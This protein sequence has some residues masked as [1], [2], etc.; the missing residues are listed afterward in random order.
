MTKK[1]KE[2]PKN[3]SICAQITSKKMMCVDH[4]LFSLSTPV[5]LKLYCE[6]GLGTECLNPP[7]D[8]VSLS[9]LQNL[10]LFIFFFLDFIYS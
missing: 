7:A 3:V 5:V 8:V 10:H 4:I 9:G 1:E 6:T 2:D